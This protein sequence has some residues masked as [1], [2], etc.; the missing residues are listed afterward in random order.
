MVPQKLKV[1]RLERRMVDPSGRGSVW[2]QP[3]DLPVKREL[4]TTV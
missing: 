2:E 1:A 4:I 3:F